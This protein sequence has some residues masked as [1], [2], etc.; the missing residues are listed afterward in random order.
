MKKLALAL[1]CLVSIAFFA[2]CDPKEGQPTIQVLNETGYV[3]NNATVNLGEEVNFGFVMASSAVTN[4][5]LSTLVVSIDDDPEFT[6]TIDLTGKFDYK[7]VGSI[8]YGTA[9]DEIIGTSVIKAIVTDAAGE[10]A[11]ATITLTINQPDQPLEVSNITWK[12][13]GSAVPSAEEMA[14][15]GLKWGNNYKEV[16]TTLLPLNDDVQMYVCDGDDF[17]DIETMSDKNAY[18]TS[19]AETAQPVENYRK[20]TCNASDDYNDM[21]AIVNGDNLY[22]IHITH[23]TITPVYN[24]NNVYLRTDITI[25]GK[26]K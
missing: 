7:Y 23:A 2:S 12:R 17:A 19:L 20:I 18:F 9:K 3:Q 21:L 6:D 5:E 14:T 10:T 26:V 22:L 1:V 4:K 13:E 11:T 8:S 25:D 16:F 24:S 15:Y